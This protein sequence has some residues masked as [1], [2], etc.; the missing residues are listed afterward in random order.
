FSNPA[1]G[2]SFL[3]LL[4]ASAP[5]PRRTSS[6]H[7]LQSVKSLISPAL[8]AAARRAAPLPRRAHGGGPT[9]RK[10]KRVAPQGT[11]ELRL[12]AHRGNVGD[13][14]GVFDSGHGGLTVFRALVRR[15][16]HIAFVYLGDHRNVPYGNRSSDEIVALTRDA[17]CALFRSGC[18]LVLLGCN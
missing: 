2:R 10:P 14:I 12:R 18:K 1:L 15:F 4:P 9:G 6:A 13:M 11:V 7:V 8:P 3:S 17:V 16:P 5:H